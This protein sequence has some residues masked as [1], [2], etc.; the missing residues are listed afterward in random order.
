MTLSTSGIKQILRCEYFNILFII[1]VC[2]S[3]TM[4]ACIILLQIMYN[5][6]GSSSYISN[7]GIT[8][9]K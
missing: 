8:L 9:M 1:K 6:I 3:V 7:N 5:V 4:P 2:F